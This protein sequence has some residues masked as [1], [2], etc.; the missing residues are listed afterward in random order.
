MSFSLVSSGS[1]AHGQLANGTIDDAHTFLPCIFDDGNSMKL[2]IS[3]KIIHIATGGNHTLLLSESTEETTGRTKRSLWGCG[4]NARGQLANYGRNGDKAVFRRIDLQLAENDLEDYQPRLLCCSWETS[5]VVLSREGNP[6]LL[7]SMGS[8]DF[9]DLG[10]G[11]TVRT[12]LLHTV[13]FDHL[14]VDGLA[15]DGSSLQVISISAGQ[16]HVITQLQTQLSDQSRRTLIIGWGAARH[17]QLGDTSTLNKKAPFFSIP[18]IIDIT[19]CPDD[20]VVQIALGH[21]HSV[22]LHESGCLSYSGSNRKSQISGLDSFHDVLYVGCT[23]NGT[24]F[25]DASGTVYATGSSSKGQLGR[26]SRVDIPSLIQPYPVEFPFTMHSMYMSR[27]ACG[28]EHVLALFSEP[29]LSPEVWGWGW[30]EHGNMGSCSTMDVHTPLKLW[31]RAA[32][33]AGNIAIGIWAGCGTS[34]IALARQSS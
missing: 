30:N 26:S 16:H 5:Y 4:D 11:Q 14:R 19:P 13:Q 8:N 31:P 12:K 2:S 28:S 1:N 20:P 34:W 18:I 10:V 6:D 15:L 32:D 22:F 24:Y 27:I 25:I 33:D 3:E 17:G 29:G 21:H 9:R 23:W 7:I